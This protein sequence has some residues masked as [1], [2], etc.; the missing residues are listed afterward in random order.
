MG[1][2]PLTRAENV[3]R[4][5]RA[6]EAGTKLTPLYRAPQS[7]DITADEMVRA[8][9]RSNPAILKP[10]LRILMRRHGVTPAAPPAAE[11]G[12]RARTRPGSTPAP[13]GASERLE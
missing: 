6:R 3:I 13:M 12:D 9:E 11:A 1:A 8:L 4:G 5:Y 7:L 2:R 10:L